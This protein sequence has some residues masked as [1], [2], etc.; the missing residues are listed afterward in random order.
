M[1]QTELL[2][3]RNT[4]QVIEQSQYS[5]YIQNRM[6]LTDYYK[7]IRQQDETVQINRANTEQ[8]LMHKYNYAFATGRE[9]LIESEQKGLSD[10]DREKMEKK[11]AKQISKARKQY[12]NGNEYT[13]DIVKQHAEI[14]NERTEWINRLNTEEEATYDGILEDYEQKFVSRRKMMSYMPGTSEA[15][16]DFK[17][18]LGQLLAEYNYNIAYKFT[19]EYIGKNYSDAKKEIDKITDLAEYITLN[20]A[21]QVIPEA[22]ANI[23]LYKRLSYDFISFAKS[24]KDMYDSALAANGLKISSEGNGE[25]VEATAEQMKGARLKNLEAANIIKKMFTNE[26]GEEFKTQTFL[27]IDMDLYKYNDFITKKQREMQKLRDEGKDTQ[28][29]ESILIKAM[30]ERDMIQAIKDNYDNFNNLTEEQREYANMHYSVADTEYKQLKK[31]NIQLL[32]QIN[33]MYAQ[34]EINVTEVK[35]QISRLVDNLNTNMSIKELE[36]FRFELLEVSNKITRDGIE[37]YTDTAINKL[38]VSKIIYLCN[39]LRAADILAGIRTDSITLDDLTVQERNSIINNTEGEITELDIVEYAKKM[40]VLAEKEYE[41]A[42]DTY[43]R[44]ESTLNMIEQ[45]GNDKFI[46]NEIQ[47]NSQHKNVSSKILEY[48]EKY[49][50][51]SKDEEFQKIYDELNA[52]LNEMRHLQEYRV[53][54]AQSNK[55]IEQIEEEMTYIQIIYRLKRKNYRVYGDNEAPKVAPIFRGMGIF[56]NDEFAYMTDEEFLNMAKKLSAG[57]FEKDVDEATKIQYAKDNLEGLKILKDKSIERYKRLYNKYGL[58][59]K[60]IDYIQEH[61]YEIKN[62]FSFTQDDEQQYDIKGVLNKDNVNDIILFH[63]MKLYSD[64]AYMMTGV[65]KTN[66]AGQEGYNAYKQTIK[67]KWDTSTKEHYTYLKEH[68]GDILKL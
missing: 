16:T 41:I 37:N 19:P 12:A 17:L 10:K 64:F 2:K 55:E 14:N 1:D 15:R 13:L 22:D 23:P 32:E 67:D 43:M 65:L 7:E 60:D 30:H 9:G 51:I 8:A 27:N 33:V 39:K 34:E 31:S 49:L 3:Q 50:E 52:K 42:Q 4:T 36:Y 58:N 6:Q 18:N 48:T 53:D 59:I 61:Y 26:Y 46:K 24:C 28:Q 56:E 21:E 62:D 57:T 47:L 5:D 20:N 66:I 29:I 35:E 38:K 45:R 40:S 54:I 68:E 63:L 11:R 25:L 44:D